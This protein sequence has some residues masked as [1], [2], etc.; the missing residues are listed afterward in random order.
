MLGVIVNIEEYF[1]PTSN[2]GMH[3]FVFK[4]VTLSLVS[5]KF[6]GGFMVA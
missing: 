3:L 6:Q 1:E 2:L 5:Y 4:V